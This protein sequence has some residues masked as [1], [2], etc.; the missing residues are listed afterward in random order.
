MNHAYQYKS[1]SEAAR[2]MVRVYGPLTRESV[3]YW[4]RIHRNQLPICEPHNGAVAVCLDGLQERGD[5][6]FR[7][8]LWVGLP[9]RGEW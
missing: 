8:G 6:E 1:L 7:A 5:V 4:L 3:E 2:A 9:G